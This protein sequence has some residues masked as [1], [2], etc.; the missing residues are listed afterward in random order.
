MLFIQGTRWKLGI[1]L[2]HRFLPS[3]CRANLPCTIIGG[4]SVTRSAYFVAI[5]T[6]GGRE[7]HVNNGK[8]VFQ[9][10]IEAL[11]I[12]GRRSSGQQAPRLSA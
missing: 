12:H 3:V 5:C 7:A 1:C 10:T 2:R 4:S 6:A 9:F 11:V 8:G